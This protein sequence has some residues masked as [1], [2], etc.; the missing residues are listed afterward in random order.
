MYSVAQAV[1][2]HLPSWPS[3]PFAR[4]TVVCHQ[5]KLLLAFSPDVIWLSLYLCGPFILLQWFIIY[6][7]WISWFP[8]YQIWGSS[9]ILEI[10]RMP[11]RLRTDFP[12]LAS[13]F[14]T[15]LFHV[16]CLCVSWLTLNNSFTSHYQFTNSLLSVQFLVYSTTSGFLISRNSIF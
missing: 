10:M 8:G 4:I 7:D 11:V 13:R 15:P 12:L 16:F 5:A 2:K 9:V 14:L 1:P 6:W 3:L